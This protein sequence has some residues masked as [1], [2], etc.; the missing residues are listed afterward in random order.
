MNSTRTEDRNQ[1]MREFVQNVL[2]DQKFKQE[3]L[4]EFVM[5]LL[6]DQKI[7]H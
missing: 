7:E 3:I 6:R 2:T 5:N 1:D 4:K